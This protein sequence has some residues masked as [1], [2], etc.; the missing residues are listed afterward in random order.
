[1]SSR[2]T[3]DIGGEANFRRGRRVIHF[4]VADDDEEWCAEE[5][6]GNDREMEVHRDTQQRKQTAALSTNSQPTSPQEQK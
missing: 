3:D 2:G 6:T 5:I 4:Q 1:M